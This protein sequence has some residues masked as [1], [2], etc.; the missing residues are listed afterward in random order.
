M[1]CRRKRKAPPGDRTA[2]AGTHGHRGAD[3]GDALRRLPLRSAYLGR[4]LR[5]GWWPEN[6]AGGPIEPAV[7]GT[8]ACSGFTVYSAIRKAMPVPPREAI[9]LVGAGGLGLNAIKVLLAL[10]H[11]NIISVDISAEKRETALAAG[12]HKA[13]D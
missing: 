10:R 2:H 8:Y 5:R 11:Q 3:R 6:V 7:A 13:V 4:L 1:G 9:V 12:A